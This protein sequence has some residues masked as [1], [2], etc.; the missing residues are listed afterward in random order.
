MKRIAS[1]SAANAQQAAVAAHKKNPKPLRAGPNGQFATL[2]RSTRFAYGGP[3]AQHSTAQTQRTRKMLAQ[4]AR[5]RRLGRGKQGSGETDG[6]DSSNDVDGLPEFDVPGDMQEH[7]GGH[8]GGRGNHGGDRDD[9]NDAEPTTVAF[10]SGRRHAAAAPITPPLPTESP[11]TA[12]RSTDPNS[13]REACTREL[14]AL[15]SELTEQQGTE[16][17]ARVHAWST[18]WLGIQ[19]A[20]TMLP[21]ADINTLR[22]H[23]SSRSSSV[24]DTATLSDAARD[25]NLLV[26]LLLR[27]FDRHR[28]SRQRAIALHTLRAL[29]REP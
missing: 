23:A 22:T 14:L 2:Y 10:K 16:L 13:L 26:G 28:T 15:Q 24:D 3:P 5:R 25:F 19:Q 20:G 27:Q 29:R 8:G 18:R 21:E 11:A 17:T 12:S 1:H 9:A 4:L 6:A 7:H